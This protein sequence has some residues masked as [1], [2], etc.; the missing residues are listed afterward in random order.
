MTHGSGLRHDV[1]RTFCSHLPAVG[2]FGAFHAGYRHC[3]PEAAERER[4]GV[5]HRKLD[6]ITH[7]QFSAPLDV[8]QYTSYNIF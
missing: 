5:R 1:V 6:H 3:S 7:R 4:D 2:F 8:S